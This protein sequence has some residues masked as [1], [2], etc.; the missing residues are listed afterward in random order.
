MIKNDQL[1]I[2]VIIYD[3]CSSFSL[4]LYIE[5]KKREEKEVAS[6]VHVL[7]L[8]S[9]KMKKYNNR[10]NIIIV[11]SGTQVLPGASNLICWCPLLVVPSPNPTDQSFSQLQSWYSQVG[12]SFA[13]TSMAAFHHNPHPSNPPKQKNPFQKI[14]RCLFFYP[15]L[16]PNSNQ[17]KTPLCFNI[18]IHS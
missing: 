3:K 4:F 10:E 17:N 7:S 15:H 16:D 5:R 13:P 18:S 9:K 12:T 2:N 11:Y 8:Q 1:V 6:Q 14:L